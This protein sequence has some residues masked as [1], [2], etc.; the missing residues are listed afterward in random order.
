MRRKPN[1]SS[2]MTAMTMRELH[3]A[4][5]VLRRMYG[6]APLPVSGLPPSPPEPAMEALKLYFEQGDHA[7]AL[8]CL[9]KLNEGLDGN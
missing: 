5:S 7:G 9:Q 3:T 2:Q 4:D 6:L 8:E 1:V